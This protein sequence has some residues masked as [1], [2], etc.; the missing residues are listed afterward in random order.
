MIVTDDP[1]LKRALKR[2]RKSQ[3]FNCLATSAMRALLDTAGVRS[4]RVAHMLARVGTVRRSLPNGRPLILWSRGDDGVSNAVYWYGWDGYEPETTPLF[5][6]LAAQ[7][8]VTLDIGA[9]VGFHSLLAGHANPAGRVYAFEPVPATLE[10]LRRH[11]ALNGLENV[12]CIAAAVGASDGATS[13]YV[14]EAGIPV[15]ASL[16]AEFVE[17]VRQAAAVRLAERVETLTVPLMTIDRFVAERS[18]SRVDLVKLDVE[19]AEP[20]ALQG[21]RAVLR[22]DRPA[23]ICEVLEDG[24]TAPALEDALRPFG[25]HA[26]HL[27]PDGPMLRE[28]VQGYGYGSCHNYLFTTEVL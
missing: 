13:L 16:S 27:T 21:M 15:G 5:F 14:G 28:R 2:L 4:E 3:P 24:R 20:Q 10:R 19:G 9:N 26:Y 17:Q 8:T 6:R 1:P 12:E 11:I 25:Y 18:I 23:I 22:R 7:A